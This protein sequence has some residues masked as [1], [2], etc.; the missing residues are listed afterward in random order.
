MITRSAG[1]GRLANMSD[2]AREAGVSIATVSRALRGLPGVNQHTRDRVLRVAEELAYVVS[3]QASSLSRGQT[4]RVA[5]V[6]PKLDSWF[7]SAM[8][9][10]VESTVRGADRDVL[11][12]QVD[13]EAQRSR[14]FRDLPTRRKVDAVVLVSLPILPHEEER[15]DLMG[16]QVVV[17]GARLRDFPS[18]RVDDVA[19]AV[20][21][22]DHLASHGHT[23]I[24]MIRAVDVDG[25][26]WTSDVHRTRGYR[27]AL[28]A[29]GF[30]A[31]DELLVAEE[32]DAAAGSRGIARLLAL[33]RPPS[34]VFCYSDDV[35][36]GALWTAQQLGVR[37]PGDLSLVG[38][39][40]HPLTETFGITTVDQHVREQA[41]L[42]GEMALSLLA[43]IPL[44]ERAVVLESDLVERAST[45]PPRSQP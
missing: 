42:A 13:G 9:A 24:G 1:D 29:H 40:G 8:M 33:D 39:D 17:A 30:D 4:G 38:V 44:P 37:V 28:A 43:G 34:A 2:V 3:P 26:R 15:L 20:K 7:S 14:F 45:G 11:L 27:E 6:V 18:V 16:V 31:H 10:T 22:V 36:I 41:R 5:I 25:T 12:Y 21:A 23:R 35:A 19:I 32:Y